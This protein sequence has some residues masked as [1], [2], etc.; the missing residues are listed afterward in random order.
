MLSSCATTPLSGCCLAV[1]CSICYP[2]VLNRAVRL[3]HNADSM[4]TSFATIGLSRHLTTLSFRHSSV[5]LLHHLCAL[6][7]RCC[8]CHIMPP[9]H[10]PLPRCPTTTPRSSLMAGLDSA[11]TRRTIARCGKGTFIRSIVR[12]FVIVFRCPDA[13]SASVLQPVYLLAF[14]STGAPSR[15]EACA[16][17]V[18]M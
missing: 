17:A 11:N 1:A 13:I 14:F 4:L 8:Q 15:R 6:L 3:V 7:S 9:P 18:L 10:C 16:L 2:V 12:C 5:S